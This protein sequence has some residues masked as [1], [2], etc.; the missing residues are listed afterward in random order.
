[1]CDLGDILVA[2]IAASRCTNWCLHCCCILPSG[3]VL[4][5]LLFGSIGPRLLWV[6]VF[7]QPW[8]DGV[9]PWGRWPRSEVGSAE[10]YIVNYKSKWN[11]WQPTCRFNSSWI[12]RHIGSLRIVAGDSDSRPICTKSVWCCL[13]VYTNTSRW[14]SADMSYLIYM[15][16]KLFDGNVV[17]WCWSQDS[18]RRSPESHVTYHVI[19]YS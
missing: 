3:T 17:W 18:A 9:E 5:R 1:M 14:T 7:L 6:D 10:D 16:R 12:R 4:K 8:L 19:M 11:E 13:F 2:T 15:K